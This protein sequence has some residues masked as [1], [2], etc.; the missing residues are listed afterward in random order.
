M[1]VLQP[2]LLMYLAII[3]AAIITL[4]EAQNTLH[5]ALRFKHALQVYFLQ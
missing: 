5:H 3:Y 4:S 2:Y 1:A